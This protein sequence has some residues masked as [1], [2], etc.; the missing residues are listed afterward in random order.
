MTSTSFTVYLVV[1]T[2]H[3]KI[4]VYRNVQVHCSGKLYFQ[5]VRLLYHIVQ[6]KT[7]PLQL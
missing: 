4:R 2:F 7:R 6:Q 3:F 5:T 1:K